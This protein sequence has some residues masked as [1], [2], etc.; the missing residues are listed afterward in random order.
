MSAWAKAYR[1]TAGRNLVRPCDFCHR[2][3]RKGEVYYDSVTLCKVDDRNDLLKY[4]V[5]Y[6]AQCESKRKRRAERLENC[7][8]RLTATHYRYIP[9]EAVME[10]D[11]DYCIICGKT[12]L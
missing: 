2:R 11:Y 6:C 12:I 5:R 8:H 10:P 1:K 7:T 4:V 3:I 9:G